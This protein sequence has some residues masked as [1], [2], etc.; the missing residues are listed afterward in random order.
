MLKMGQIRK[1]QCVWLIGKRG[2]CAYTK[3][4]LVRASRLRFAPLRF[5]S[6]F[7]DLSFFIL[8]TSFFVLRTSSVCPSSVV[9][10]FVVLSIEFIVVCVN[11][12]VCVCACVRACVCARPAGRLPRASVRAA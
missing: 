9:L 10:C 5:A 3:K 11:V 4:A 2:G 6:S 7:F 12:C 1:M 8:R